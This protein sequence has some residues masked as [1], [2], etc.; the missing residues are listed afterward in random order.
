VT[1][2]TIRSVPPIPKPDRA[3]WQSAAIFA[4]ALLGLGFLFLVNPATAGWIPP[5]PL[6]ALTGFNCPGCGSLRA[7]HSVLHLQWAQALAYNPLTCLCL[8]FVGGWWLWH[9]GR[10][11]TGRSWPIPF[12]R[13]VLLWIVVGMV[14]LFGIV[15]NIPATAAHKHQSNTYLKL[16][17]PTTQDS[18]GFSSEDG[19]AS[20]GIP[21]I[22]GGVQL[23][24]DPLQ[25]E[26]PPPPVNIH[27]KTCIFTEKLLKS[28]IVRLTRRGSCRTKDKAQ[29][30]LAHSIET[31]ICR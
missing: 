12:I 5:C 28:G 29:A 20:G 27:V 8:P 22:F 25:A 2:E 6:H 7:I 30:T 15:R 23:Q 13:P 17:V 3:R 31:P 1:P 19:S 14:F 18:A 9:A 11:A 16:T 4:G 10:A 24:T 21:A 26:K